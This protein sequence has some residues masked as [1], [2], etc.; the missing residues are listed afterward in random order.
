[1]ARSYRN[2][3]ASRA[4]AHRLRTRSGILQ[5]GLLLAAAGSAPAQATGI[6]SIGFEYENDMFAGEDRYYTSGVR[7][8]WTRSGD[9][10]PLWLQRVANALPLFVRPE[11]RG[12]LKYG[13]G[14]GQNMYTPEDIEQDPPDP[15]DRPYAGW[16]YLNFNLAEDTGNRLDR[17]QVSLGIVGPASLADRTQETV[18]DLIGS[19]Q[20]AGW[21][22][23]IR[24]EPTLMLAYER[25]LRQRSHRGARGWAAD[26]TPHWGIAAGSPFT[27]VNAGAIVRAG[28]NLP[29]DYG[30]PRIG[31]GLPGSSTFQS[32]TRAGGY[33]F[34][35]VDSRLMAF[36]LFLDGPA[37]RSGPSVD[38]RYPLVAEF[39]A[40]AVYQFGS[41]LRVGYTHVLRSREFSGQ[42]TGPAE[43]GALHATWQF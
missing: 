29:R 11:E 9:Y 14:L 25:Q 1:M 3:P 15:D 27:F 5:A 20:P 4:A 18:H 41:T 37:F 13:V 24:N 6:D 2:V 8:T 40:G 10:V 42:A 31:P 23:Q 28:R 43:F 34:A 12:R 33:L 35:G 16:L 19:P 22:A 17:L 36:D 39:T 32:D 26:F 7:A 21:D 38:T 30:P